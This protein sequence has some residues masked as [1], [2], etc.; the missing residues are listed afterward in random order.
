MLLIR[1]V[2][3]VCFVPFS[4]LG[5]PLSF[6]DTFSRA[7]DFNA[8][9][10]SS[11]LDLKDAEITESLSKASLRPQVSITTSHLFRDD[12]TT[13]SSDSTSSYLKSTSLGLTQSLFAGCLDYKDISIA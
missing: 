1:A 8:K 2:V 3:L 5:A 12:S 4:L 13:G 10:F 7:K 11:K 9:V 6:W